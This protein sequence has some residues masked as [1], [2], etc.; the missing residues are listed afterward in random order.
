MKDE[1]PGREGEDIHRLCYDTCWPSGSGE[2]EREREKREEEEKQWMHSRFLDRLIGTTVTE[3][4]AEV[5]TGL[6]LL[7]RGFRLSG[8]TS[9]EELA[10]G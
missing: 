9:R 5:A 6:G 4:R 3:G 8:I 10:R 1:L 7:S 2:K